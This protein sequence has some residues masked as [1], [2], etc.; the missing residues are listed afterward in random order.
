MAYNE[1]ALPTLSA[2]EPQRGVS[3]GTLS[4]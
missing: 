1:L 4:C 2:A 3:V